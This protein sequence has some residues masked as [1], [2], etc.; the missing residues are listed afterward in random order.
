MARKIRTAPPTKRKRTS[1]KTPDENEDF[2]PDSE[3]DTERVSCK[4]RRQAPCTK[5]VK[6][7]QAPEDVKPVKRSARVDKLA[8][9]KEAAR[10]NAATANFDTRFHKL[11]GG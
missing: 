3:S 2:K 8:Q 4:S 10:Q 11:P 7:K 1:K 6:T 5:Q 9:D